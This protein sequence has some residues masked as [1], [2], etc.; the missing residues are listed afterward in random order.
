MGQM[1][2]IV[3]GGALALGLLCAGGCGGSHRAAP[4]QHHCSIVLRAVATKGQGVTPAGM[5]LA[6]L[7][8]TNRLNKIGVTSPSVAVH[9]DEIVIEFAGTPHVTANAAA[10]LGETGQLQIFD[11]EP[12]LAPPT[13]TGNQQPAPR[14]SLYSLLS[15]VKREASHGTPESY[16][17]FRAKGSH[18]VMQGPAPNRKQLFRQYKNGKQ[19]ANTQVLAVPA[20]REPVF[21]RSLAVGCPGAGRSK[22]GARWY[23]FRLPPALTGKDLV[24]SGIASTVDQNSGQPIVI[25]EFTHRGAR[26][27]RRMTRAEYNRGRIN[28]GLGPVNANAQVNQTAI[29]RNAGHNAIVLDGRLEETPYIDYT[30]STLAYGIIGNAE[31]T[32]PSATE[33]LRTA[34]VLQSGSLPYS[35]HLVK[36]GTC[37]R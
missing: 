5:Q 28:S 24:E 7:I 13:V 34:L 27:F 9:G 19:P 16:Y 33:A 12:S 1:K 10:T 37:P 18:A 14:S 6:R 2:R 25:L 4:E 30:N 31:I 11:F 32:E 26:A 3:A 17:L 29:S 35:F 36:G 15:A 21:C 8:M 22:S 23:L 20:R